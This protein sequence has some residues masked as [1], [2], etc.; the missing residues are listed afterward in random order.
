MKDTR[1]KQLAVSVLVPTKNRSELLEKTLRALLDQTRTPDEILVVDNGSTDNTDKVV[2]AIAARH[3]QVRHFLEPRPGVV[4]ARNSAIQQ[5][6]PASEVVLFLD[7]D[8]I[9]PRHWVEEMLMPL[10]YDEKIVSVGGG[11][12]FGK[13]N[14]TAWG[15][16]Y[17]HQRSSRE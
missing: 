5:A 11:C 7:D 10:E 17:Y 8:C 2:K 3:P 13:D 9:P 6:D 16:F 12:A 1:R 14:R 15:D 4:H